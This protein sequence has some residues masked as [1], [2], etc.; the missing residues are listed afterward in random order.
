MGTTNSTATMEETHGTADNHRVVVYLWRVRLH[1]S[2]AL[3]QVVS[4]R[5]YVVHGSTRVKNRWGFLH[6]TQRHYLTTCI[7]DPTD[8]KGSIPFQAFTGHG[9]QITSVL[10]MSIQSSFIF[11]TAPW[12][13]L[14][15][16]DNP[17]QRV[18]TR[19]WSHQKIENRLGIH[20]TWLVEYFD[21]HDLYN[22]ATMQ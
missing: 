22:T 5:L 3:W 15:R 18:Q 13:H 20:E 1:R 7:S 9:E 2:T 6:L 4:R 16:Q 12:V 21:F 8:R 17:Q 14:H 19:P 10:S 11:H